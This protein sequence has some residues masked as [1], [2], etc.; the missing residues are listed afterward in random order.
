MAA[1]AAMLSIGEIAVQNP[2]GT[3]DMLEY[4]IDVLYADSNARRFGTRVYA[5]VGFNDSINAI[6][7]ALTQAVIAAGAVE[8]M[9]LA[10]A[11]VILIDF[12]KGI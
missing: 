2:T 7:Q 8:G 12:Q 4:G 5:L 1:K 6:R 11:D 10:A 3:E 9:T